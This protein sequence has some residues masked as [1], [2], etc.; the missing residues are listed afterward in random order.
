MAIVTLATKYRKTWHKESSLRA[1]E[2]GVAIQKNSIFY[3]HNNIAK[4]KQGFTVIEIMC[5]MIIISIVT[6]IALPSIDNFYS[7]ERCKAEASI[8]VDYIRQAKYQAIQ[9]NSLNRIIFNEE[10]LAYKVQCYD[11]GEDSS[12]KENPYNIDEVINTYSKTTGIISSYNDSH[13]VSIVDEDEIEFNTNLE[14][15]VAS[16]TDITNNHY[17]VIYFKPDGYIY[18]S[19]GTNVSLLSEK[20]ITIKYG[21]ATIAVYINALGVISS[22]AIQNN[23]DDENYFDDDYD[24]KPNVGDYPDDE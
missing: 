24:T 2:R 20:R 18:V 16:F 1:S 8:L 17:G 5:V 9:N 12:G 23:E 11:P 3:C 19:D 14:V 13:W 21:N 10:D 4:N 6:S 22:E 7:S 15:N